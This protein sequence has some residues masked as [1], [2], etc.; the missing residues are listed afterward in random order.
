MISIA[1][2]NEGYTES[3]SFFLQLLGGLGNVEEDK[4]TYANVPIL[5][6]ISEKVDNENILISP[7]THFKQSA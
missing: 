5:A 2:Q 3:D 6:D 4:E 1:F 7:T